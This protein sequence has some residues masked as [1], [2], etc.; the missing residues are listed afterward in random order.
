MMIH[1]VMVFQ[2]ESY[3]VIHVSV[4]KDL[5]KEIFRKGKYHT[6]D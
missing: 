2:I 6:R 4:Q 5:N 3:A 1:Y